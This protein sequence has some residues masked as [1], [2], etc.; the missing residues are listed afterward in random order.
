MNWIQKSFQVDV[1][2]FVGAIN[3]SGFAPMVYEM[4]GM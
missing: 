4:P 2:G 3:G 1:A